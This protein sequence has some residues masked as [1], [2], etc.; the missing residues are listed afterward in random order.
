MSARSAPEIQ[1]DIPPAFT[2]IPA[3]KITAIFFLAEGRSRELNRTW[4]RDDVEMMALCI[5][6]SN[7]VCYF[8]ILFRGFAAVKELNIVSPSPHYRVYITLRRVF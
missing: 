5:V 8:T 7:E 2:Q 4:G 1:I 3:P 6:Y